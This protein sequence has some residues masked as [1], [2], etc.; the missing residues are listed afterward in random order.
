MRVY[1]AGPITVG[2]QEQNVRNAIAAG[3]DLFRQGYTP[4]IPH[5]NWYWHQIYE[6]SWNE[7]IKYGLRLL[8]AC[9]CL[10]RLP[11]QSSGADI[12][13]EEAKR[14]GIPVVEYNGSLNPPMPSVFQSVLREIAELHDAKQ[15]DYGRDAD[16]FANIRASEEFGI[17]AWLGAVLRGND[18]MSRL[19]TFTQKQTLKNESVEDSLKD[20]AVYAL[21]ALILYREIEGIE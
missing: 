8:S 1:I 3:E 17:P 9:E 13:V 21:I 5:L 20:L 2:D 7:W 18:K 15:H 16:P 11:G 14:L 4:I 12:E 19:K 10:Y 6:H